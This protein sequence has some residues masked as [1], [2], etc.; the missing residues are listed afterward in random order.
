MNQIV[1]YLA[2]VQKACESCHQCQKKRPMAVCDRVSIVTIKKD[3]VSGSTVT[4]D[5]QSRENLQLTQGN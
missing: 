4:V 5:F 1:V 2:D 3:R